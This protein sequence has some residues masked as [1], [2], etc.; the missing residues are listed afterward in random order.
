MLP[1]KDL[2][3]YKDKIINMTVTITLTTAGRDVNNCS[4]YSNVDGYVTPFATGVTRAQL[5]GGYTSTVVPNG[6]STIRVKPIGT[7]CT[8]SLDVTVV[9]T[10]TTTTTGASAQLNWSFTEFG[11]SVGNMDLYING[12]IVES[13]SNTSSGTLTVYLGDAINVEVYS[14]GCDSSTNKANV[15]TLG[16]IADASCGDGSATLFTGVYTVTAGDVGT[17]LTL[18]TFAS[19]NDGCI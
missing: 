13:R 11:G 15:Y 6:T 8:N 10:T 1:N 14:S 5:L 18:S 16:I 12:S 19:C 2:W 9:T 3:W 7:T 17:T 4:L